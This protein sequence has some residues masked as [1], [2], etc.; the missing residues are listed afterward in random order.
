MSNNPNLL[1]TLANDPEEI[2]TTVLTDNSPVLDVELMKRLAA[3]RLADLKSI[4]AS[5]MTTDKG[6]K[7][8]KKAVAPIKA[9]FTG[10]EKNIKILKK[11][12]SDIPKKCDAVSKAL[13][14]LSEPEIEKA[15]APLKEL[16]EQEK[17]VEKW[18]KKE[19]IPYNR[20]QLESGL[21]V[22]KNAEPHP[23]SSEAE[24]ADFCKHKVDYLAEWEKCL[25]RIYTEEKADQ[26]AKERAAK[27]AERLRQQAK[28]QS[29]IVEALRV[30]EALLREAK[31]RFIADKEKFE[32]EQKTAAV[33]PFN[34][35]ESTAS[36]SEGAPP[37]HSREA[38]AMRQYALAA[39]TALLG[40]ADIALKVCKAIFNEEI[41]NV[42]FVYG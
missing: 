42:R 35:E 25:E 34:P 32:R 37:S 26:E 29:K 9:D 19:G 5:D 28:E 18:S 24:I 38:K 41:P 8:L 1:L 4:P 14:D 12:Y 3:E 16:E 7:S 40:D 27:E 13:R 22:L 20:C 6:R 36:S 30:D 2:L 11:I 15:L 31:E 33:N 39:M 23:Y 10:F 21:D 17:L